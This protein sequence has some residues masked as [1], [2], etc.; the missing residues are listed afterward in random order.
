MKNDIPNPPVRFM[1]DG[2]LTVFTDGTFPAGFHR[3]AG[4]GVIA[5]GTQDPGTRV[6]TPADLIAAD[7]L[8]PV[9]IPKLIGDWKPTIPRLVIARTFEAFATYC[10]SNGL[11][12]RNGREA[13]Y[14]T[15]VDQIAGFRGIDAY[16]VESGDPSRPYS[17]RLHEAWERITRQG[18]V[19]HRVPEDRPIPRPG[20][21]PNDTDGD[22]DC[23][24]P[25]CP[26][27]KGHGQL[28]VHDSYQ[29]GEGVDCPAC[30][31]G[32]LIVLVVN[33]NAIV[34]HRQGWLSWQILASSILKG[35]PD[36]MTGT[37]VLSSLDAT[38]PATVADFEAFRLANPESYGITA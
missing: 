6:A 1:V 35:G 34:C 37:M 25:A 14:L 20:G 15:N 9:T 19:I 28:P 29:T 2:Q 36:P 8:A 21:C 3:V 7:L 38:R 13:I 31:P 16:L 24:R 26:T 32:D 23:G 11:N 4:G 18:G 22:G 10:R 12:P 27:C 5:D 30:R 33:E 17:V